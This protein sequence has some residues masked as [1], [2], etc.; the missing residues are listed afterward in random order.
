MLAT[1]LSTGASVRNRILGIIGEVRDRAL[2]L[3]VKSYSGEYPLLSDPMNFASSSSNG[4]SLLNAS[5][6]V[7]MLQNALLLPSEIRAVER[8]EPDSDLKHFL[9]ESDMHASNDFSQRPSS[10]SYADI[11][12]DDGYESEIEAEEMAATNATAA[13]IPELSLYR[14]CELNGDRERDER[15]P[16]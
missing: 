8:I 9:S 12:D 6:S 11:L 1:C 4:E 7:P 15:R 14:T 13:S 16:S 3:F 2:A 5:E 10:R